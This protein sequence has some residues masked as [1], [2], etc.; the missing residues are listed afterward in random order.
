MKGKYDIPSLFLVGFEGIFG[1][2]LDA[3]VFLPVCYFIPGDDHGSYENFINSAYMMFKNPLLLGLQLLYFISI[4]FFNF[5]ALTISKILS[6][7]HR[8]L[9]DALRTASVWVC[10]VICYY[11]TLSSKPA[12]GNQPYG[13]EL[14]WYSFIE[15]FGFICMIFGTLVHNNVS[16]FGVKVM[17]LLH[18]HEGEVACCQSKA[19]YH[20]VEENEEEELVTPEKPAE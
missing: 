19:Q 14:N 12:H 5:M 13:E 16:G 11:A 7:T 9:I 8:A 20:K 15:A 18:I 6:A 3:F 4:S 1:S 10:M 2:C 17:R